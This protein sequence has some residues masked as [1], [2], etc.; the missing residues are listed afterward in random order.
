MA[1]SFDGFL[2][3]NR[4]VHFPCLLFVKWDECGHC[5]NL[6]PKMKRVRESLKKVMPVYVLDAQIHEKIISRLGVDGF[7]EIFIANKNK[8]C[9]KIDERTADAIVK[10]A[11]KYM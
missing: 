9:R 2:K 7:P 4:N 5:H 3:F 11:L 6:A 1:N 8:R 10:N